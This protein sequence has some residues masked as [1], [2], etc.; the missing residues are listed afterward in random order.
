MWTHFFIN[1]VQY[2]LPDILCI[3]TEVFEK[4]VDDHG[5]VRHSNV[6]PCINAKSVEDE[7]SWR[8]L[9]VGTGYQVAVADREESNKDKVE[10]VQKAPALHGHDNNCR[11]DY[12]KEMSQQ[13]EY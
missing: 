8:Q 11:Y 3:L 1:N 13:H 2:F 5:Q 7:P 10:R 9:R 6:H 4:Q 12:E